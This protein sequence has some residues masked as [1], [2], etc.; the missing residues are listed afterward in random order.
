MKLLD[1]LKS[2]IIE[3][4]LIDKF[5]LDGIDVE[6]RSTMESEVIAPNSKTG[7]VNK[8]EILESMG[9]IYDVIIKQA[10][11]VTSKEDG[12]SA[13]LISDYWLGFDYQLWVKFNK[14]KLT[15]TINTS[16]RHPK[17]L[18][19]KNFNTRRIII[20]KDGETIIKESLDGYKI[21]KVKGKIIYILD[22]I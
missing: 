12:N 16:I 6:I 3:S 4:K 11:I 15:L 21:L 22:D 20:T 13:L 5:T 14:N 8:D 9:D 1:V 17:L 2:L 10:M 18:S 19:N 7:R